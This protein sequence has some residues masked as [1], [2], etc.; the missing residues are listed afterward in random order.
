[1]SGAEGKAKTENRSRGPMTL[2]NNSISSFRF[3]EIM[4][5]ILT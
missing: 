1:M 2:G 5:I 3:P 4:I